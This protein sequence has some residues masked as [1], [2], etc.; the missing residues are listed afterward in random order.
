MLSKDEATNVNANIEYTNN[1]KCFKYKTELLGNTEADRAN[2]VL[3]NTAI[4][5]SLKYLSNFR[6]SLEMLLINCKIELK[7]KWMNHCVLSANVNENDN[8][9]SS[10][11]IFT[12]KATKLHVP[13]VCSH[14][15]SKK[16]LKM[17]KT[18]YQKT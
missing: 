14:F 13:V 18:S 16:Q 17:I 11:I 4:A 6:K 5:G 10:N 8:A 2:G 1:F 3:K 12:I 7:L 15:I 9:N